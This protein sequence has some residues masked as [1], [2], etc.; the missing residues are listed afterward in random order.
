MVFFGSPVEICGG[1][2][3]GASSYPATLSKA[4]HRP[5]QTVKVQIR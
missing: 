1:C 4:S 2:W 5:C 3:N